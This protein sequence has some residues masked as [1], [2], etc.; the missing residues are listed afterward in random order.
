VKYVFRFIL[1]VMLMTVAA[2][3]DNPSGEFSPVDVNNQDEVTDEAPEVSP[4]ET[5]STSPSDSS[6]HSNIN[7]EE[8]TTSNQ[9]KN[10]DQ[11]AEEL[12]ALIKARDAESLL[13]VLNNSNEVSYDRS[14][15]NTIL[16][17]FASNFDLDTLSVQF[18]E[19]GITNSP[20]SGQYEYILIDKNYNEIN[21]EIRLT[22]RYPYDGGVVYHNPYIRYFPYAELMA[23]EYVNLIKE[24]KIKELAG[25]LNPDDVIVPDWVAEEIISSYKQLL[26]FETMSVRYID[27]FNFVIEDGMGKEHDIKVIYGDG[28]MN[29]EDPLI[30]EFDY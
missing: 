14:E 13:Q 8:A 10:P 9:E 21:D 25:F 30:P 5:L 29:I 17:G 15:V 2:C 26:S 16:E 4:E 1:I 22:V 11:A 12:V 6:E 20:E 23:Q 27:E 24:E 7:H 19:D 18:N 28:L 3:G